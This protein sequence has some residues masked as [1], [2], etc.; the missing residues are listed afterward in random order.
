MNP[1]ISERIHWIGE[2][3]QAQQAF[4]SLLRALSR[5]CRP[6]SLPLPEGKTGTLSPELAAIA[7]T[8]CDQDTG[9]WLSPSLNSKEVR[10]WFRFQCGAPTLDEPAG[11]AF[12]F[13]AGPEEIPDL[14]TLAQ[15]TP[16]YPDR[17]A[18]LCAG[19]MHLSRTQEK[20]QWLACGPGIREPLPFCCNLP[21]GFLAQWEENHRSFPQGIDMFLCGEG[22]VAGLPRSTS[23][24][25][26]KENRVCM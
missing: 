8:M 22:M 24:T 5:P 7:L 17:S 9:V 4:R 19:G 12:V 3:R 26:Y 23:L 6:V 21:E 20:P 16:E 25:P 14:S 11:A 13:V 18:T 1:T 2:V 15:G 10:H